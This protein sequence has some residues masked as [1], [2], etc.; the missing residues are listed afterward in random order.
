MVRVTAKDAIKTD[1]R[2]FLQLVYDQGTS[3]FFDHF[4]S[5]FLSSSS[6]PGLLW[7]LGG[8]L[9]FN[10]S[11]RVVFYISVRNGKDSFLSSVYSE[12]FK[13][14]LIIN[15]ISTSQGH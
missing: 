5:L 10:M 6:L 13:S 9:W 1:I 14:G 3:Y 8:L 2:D 4:I 12:G 15:R 7:L 11:F